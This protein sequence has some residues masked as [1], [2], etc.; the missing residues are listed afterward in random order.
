[1]IIR[2]K[3][4]LIQN[5]HI[6]FTLIAIVFFIFIYAC[7]KIEH[8]KILKIT[9][10]EI[11]DTTTTTATVKGV[12]IDAGEK[13]INEHGHCWSTSQNPTVSV[14]TKT[15]LGSNNS[16]G[17]F[18]SR[19]TNL[20]PG[21]T[22]YVKAYA[23]N[24]EETVYGNETSFSTSDTLPT[25]STTVISNITWNSA[26]SGGNA[27]ANGG[28]P[29]TT[30]GVCWSNSQNPTIADAFTTDG[31]GTGSFT[32][33]ITGLTPNTTYYVRAY[34]TNSAGTGYGNEITFK[35][36]GMLNDSRDG[37][38]YKTIEIGE[39]WWM[40]ENLN[41][42]TSNG[43][44][45][46][47]DDSVTYVETYGRLYTWETAK[48]VCPA[49]WH[50]PTDS[51]WKELEIYLGMTQVQAD[52]TGWR[53]TDQGIQLSIDGNSRFE[54]LLAGYRFYTG[55][56]YDLGTSAYFWSSTEASNDFARCRFLSKETNTGINRTGFLKESGFS[57]RCVQD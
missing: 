3:I 8:E 15:Q 23:T 38:I 45:Y 51:E 11:T 4:R 55:A 33:S 27:T 47:K 26:T 20:S 30:R 25:I 28:A 16:A 9:T 37:Q 31:S 43:S 13:G 32:S 50:L 52:N 42:Y 49:G 39:Q 10:G 1:M 21:I 53:G 34:A 36:Y 17:S 7:E 24:S 40:A 56:F 41:F 5:F 48:N 54:A 46:Y 35:T 57:V 2:Q 18:T 22:Y 19:L 29:I 12:I 14:S 6:L 44:W